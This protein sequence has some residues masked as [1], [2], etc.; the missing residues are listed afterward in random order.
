MLAELEQITDK[1]PTLQTLKLVVSAIKTLDKRTESMAD[2]T[3][4]QDM[5]VM[6]AIVD[7][8]NETNERLDR[9]EGRL[10]NLETEVKGVKSELKG[11]N[12][13]LGNLENSQNEMV[14]LLKVIAENTKK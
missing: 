2:L 10:A 9:V 11:V 12:Q 6:S 1:T 5:S 14:D 7:L 3:G 13:R 8:K 4:S